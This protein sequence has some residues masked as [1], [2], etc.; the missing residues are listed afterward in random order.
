MTPIT[1]F[2]SYPQPFYPDWKQEP[3]PGWGVRPVMAGPR[4]VAVGQAE[5]PTFAPSEAFRRAMA[6]ALAEKK[7]ADLERLRRFKGVFA[8]PPGSPSDEFQTASFASGAK[9]VYK[10]TWFIASAAVAAL[11]VAYLLYSK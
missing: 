7:A 5:S 2:K 8:P 9:P 10:E 6:K 1:Y 3:V 4:M 11:G